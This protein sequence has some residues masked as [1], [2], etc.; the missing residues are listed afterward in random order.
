[1]SPSVRRT[2]T[3]RNA[4]ISDRSKPQVESLSST[5][6]RKLPRDN[7][8]RSWEFVYMVS[9]VC[10]HVI[11]RGSASVNDQYHAHMVECLATLQSRTESYALSSLRSS[12]RA[13]RTLSNEF[14]SSNH[15]L[16]NGNTT[17]KLFSKATTAQSGNT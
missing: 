11:S 3:I 9:H 17:K 12:S 8:A 10:G 2:P 13:S 1:M 5:T 4:I 7:P 15:F 16:Q 14:L 6:R